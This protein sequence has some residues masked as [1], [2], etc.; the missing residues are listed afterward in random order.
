MPT[1]LG[2]RSKKICN[3][4]YWNKHYLYNKMTLD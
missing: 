4:I 3:G 1:L 2:H